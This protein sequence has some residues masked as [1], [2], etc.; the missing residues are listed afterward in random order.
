MVIRIQKIEEVLKICFKEVHQ[1]S[2]T[3]VSLGLFFKLLEGTLRIR[4]TGNHLESFSST[5]K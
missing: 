5:R 2:K 3:L 1:I 4:S